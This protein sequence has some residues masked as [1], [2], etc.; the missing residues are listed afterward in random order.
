VA[1]VLLTALAL[2][3]RL[4]GIGGDLWLDEIATVLGSVRPP[5]IETLT[6]YPNAN[7]HVLY[8]VLAH[9]SVALFGETAW[10]VRLPALLF[11]VA[12]VPALYWLV[13][14][15]FERREA[16]GA[17]LVLALSYHHAYFAHN[18][19][20]YTGFLFFT[21]VTTALLVRAVRGNQRHHWT[22]FA[23]LAALSSYLLLSAVFVTALQVAGA[24]WMLLFSG[25][26]GEQ[27]A[28]RLLELVKWTVAAALLTLFLYAPLLG[29]MFA[30]FG[31]SRGDFIGWRPSFE[32]ARVV[33]QAVAPG[34]DPAIAGAVLLL[35]APVAVVGIVSVARRAP[36][37]V[38][39]FALAPLLEIAAG[40]VLGAG[41]YPRRLLLLLPFGII[42]AVRGVAVLTAWAAERLAQPRAE[43]PA[44]VTCLVLGALVGAAGL[45]R[46]FTIPMQDYRGAL[47]Y[48]R[49]NR[50]PDDVVAAAWVTDVGVRYYD[51]SVRSVRSREQLQALLEGGGTVWVLETLRGQTRRVRPALVALLQ[52]RFRPVAR[53]PGLVGD[54]GIQVLRSV[55]GSQ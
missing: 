11:G 6:S 44:F 37:L 14:T 48:V 21:V 45:P 30:F 9:V 24:A 52:E 36:L 28:S 2:V 17:S 3:V 1:L 49:R 12:T 42:V 46:L 34:G 20:A 39:A 29:D 8:S 18:A 27:R 47:E 55:E 23:L 26:R 41:T 7:T 38:F 54:G 16:L 50:G 25:Q 10:A 43:L 13:R 40:L 4:P 22:L 15:W 32:L 51:P 31:G 33:L 5:L 35:G 19:R 53:F